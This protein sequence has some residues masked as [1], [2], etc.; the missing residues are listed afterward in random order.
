[1]GTETH[2]VYRH[3]ASRDRWLPTFWRRASGRCLPYRRLRLYACGANCAISPH[4]GAGGR[5][6]VKRGV[7][8]G[9][10]GAIVFIAFVFFGMGFLDDARM[11]ERAAVVLMGLAFIPLSMMI[12]HEREQS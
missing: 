5:E 2:K 1:M 11:V 10:I 8:P 4:R 6:G 7:L 12:F 3:P 9:L